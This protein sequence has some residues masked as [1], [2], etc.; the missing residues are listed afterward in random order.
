MPGEAPG[1][2]AAGGGEFVAAASLPLS[3]VELYEKRILPLARKA[4]EIRHRP[5]RRNRY[6]WPLL[7]AFLLWILALCITERQNGSAS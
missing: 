2:A 4:L 1:L 6:Q 3:L 7:A 5:E